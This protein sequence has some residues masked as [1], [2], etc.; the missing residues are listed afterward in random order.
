MSQTIAAKTMS[1]KT[2]LEPLMPLY[3]VIFIGF[4]GYSMMVTLFVQLLMG[5]RTGLLPASATEADRTQVLGLLLALYPLGQFFGTPVLSSLSDRFGRKPVLI[6]SLSVTTLC[7]VLVAT[8]LQI[9]SLALLAASLVVC[10]LAEANVAIAQSAIADVSTPSERGRLFGYA[11]V[12]VRLGYVAGP[13]AGGL[14][15]AW[16]H[17]PAMPFWFV[18]VLLAAALVWTQARF[19][20]THP[21]EPGRGIRTRDAFTSLLTVFTERRIRVLY[22]I[23]FLLFVAIFGYSRAIL[24]YLVNEWHFHD[25]KITLFYAYF[26]AA[27]L[28]A[29]LWIMPLLS[30]RLSL[31]K[32]AVTTAALGG[33]STIAIAIPR[34]EIWVWLLIGPSSCLLSLCLSACAALLSNSVGPDEQGRVMG[35]AQALEDAGEAAGAA[36]AG[37]LASLFIPLPM[38]V[39]GAL[40][41]VGALLLSRFRVPVAQ[42]GPS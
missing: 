14:I 21:P 28:V 13:L 37:L 25:R 35:N 33:L 16:T 27:V 34:S 39:Y 19:A 15:V 7:Y 23:N 32:L 42:A 4:I 9:K 31:K 18:V 41:I 10:G 24:M 1:G 6:H 8:A 22:L 26:A 12:A 3:L 38:L 5:P 17:H 20:E 2:P 40:V 36:G 29:N 30:S 11:T